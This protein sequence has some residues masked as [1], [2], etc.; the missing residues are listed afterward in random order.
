R[1]GSDRRAARHYAHRNHGPGRAGSDARTALRTGRHRRRL[2][3]RRRPGARRFRL[4]AATAVRIQ[5]A[6]RLRRHPA[7]RAGHAGGGRC[8]GR[9]RS[10]RLE[11]APRCDEIRRAGRSCLGRGAPR[12]APA[13]RRRMAKTSVSPG[14]MAMSNLVCVS[15]DFC[16]GSTLLYTLFRKSSQYYCL[17]E[18]LHERL[19]EYLQYRVQPDEGDHHFFMEDYYAELRPFRRVASLLDPSWGS[20]DLYLPPDAER[21]ALYRYFRYL[22]GESFGRSPGV[23]FKENR[24]AFRLGWFRR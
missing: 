14:G 12:A 11:S 15:G 22:I 24:L 20:R 6:R 7:R 21:D 3:R 9:P 23:M 17:Y 13:C 16:S 10:T 18:P 4:A 5:P 8:L 2:P 19:R 1:P